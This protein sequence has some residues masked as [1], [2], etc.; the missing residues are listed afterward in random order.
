MRVVAHVDETLLGKTDF[1]DI[2]ARAVTLEMPIK[3]EDSGR[4]ADM[5]IQKNGLGTLYYTAAMSYVPQ[6]KSPHAIN[7]GMEIH[8][9]ISVEREGKWMLL[10]NPLKIHQGELVRVDLFISLPAAGNFCGGG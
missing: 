2:N 3:E 8:K 6:G 10:T 9:E 4:R 1:K 7:A 5:I